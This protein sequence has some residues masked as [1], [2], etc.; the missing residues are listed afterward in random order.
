MPGAPQGN[1]VWVGDLYQTTG[2]W[3]GS[4]VY[5]PALFTPT[6]VGSLTLDHSPSV[7][8]AVVTYSVNGVVV[9]KNI[10]RQTLRNDSY[11]GTYVGQF[12]NVLTCSDPA[13]NGTVIVPATLTV[14]HSGNSSFTMVATGMNATCTYSG[15]YE[16]NGRFGSVNG[17]TYTCTDGTAGTFNSFE[18]Y[19][20]IAG[21]TGRANINNALCSATSHFGGMRQ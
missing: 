2:P 5:N 12:K 19:V 18:M 4:P 11:A 1:F 17:G 16:Q 7:E 3:F 20:N 9:T 15:T 10:H 8:S 13:Q 21:F 6:K 14:A